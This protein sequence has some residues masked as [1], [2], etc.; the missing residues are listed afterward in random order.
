MSALISATK[1]A[2]R[3]VFR[4]SCSCVTAC[5][6][7]GGLMCRVPIR[8]DTFSL[9]LFFFNLLCQSHAPA[10]FFVFSSIFPGCVSLFARPPLLTLPFS[11]CCSLSANANLAEV[12]QRRCST[13]SRQARHSPVASLEVFY[14]LW[15]IKCDL[16][17]NSGWGSESRP[18]ASSPPD[19]SLCSRLE[20]WGAF[21]SDF[22]VM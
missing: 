3:S 5:R 9:L 11:F 17:S 6:L 14:P 16:L 18:G 12:S 22:I 10:L 20:S 2:P 21:R 15:L 8:C 4:Q 1:T 7:S 13:E 19:S